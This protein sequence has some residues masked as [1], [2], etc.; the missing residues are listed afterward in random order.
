M[1]LSHRIA[2]RLYAANFYAKR[3][4][5]L[6]PV[7]ASFL[8][9]GK[10]RNRCPQRQRHPLIGRINY[11]CNERSHFDKKE[12]QSGRSASLNYTRV[13]QCDPVIETYDA[14]LNILLE[15]CFLFTVT[16]KNIESHSG[17]A[18]LLTSASLDTDSAA[19]S[20]GCP[21]HGCP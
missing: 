20:A 10:G 7:A 17:D 16:L 6:P 11:F 12:C 9:I 4:H 21:A 1:G 5:S 14:K 2:F 13:I 19:G 8:L 15:K 18:S 3:L